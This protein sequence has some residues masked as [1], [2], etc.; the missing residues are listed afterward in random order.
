MIAADD[1]QPIP[2]T[3]LY[4][5]ETQYFGF[6]PVSFVDSV[7]NTVNTYA[8]AALDSLQDF[9]DNE[10]GECSENERVLH[11]FMLFS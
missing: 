6:T 9:V 5:R 7:I 11:A 3:Y 8:H 2:A 1:I 4:E 10:L